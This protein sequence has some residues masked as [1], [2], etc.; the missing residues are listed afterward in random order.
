MAARRTSAARGP[1][2]RADLAH[3][4][5]L[6]MRDD[7]RRRRRESYW[8]GYG[9]GGMPGTLLIELLHQEWGAAVGSIWYDF[10]ARHVIAIRQIFV[11]PRFRRVG[12]ASILHDQLLAAYAGIERVVTGASD[13]GAALLESLGYQ[14]VAD[15][16]WELRLP[17]GRKTK[18]QA[19]RGRRRK[20]SQI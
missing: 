14:E 1:R 4:A 11:D 19:G 2:L 20:K 5:V 13:E 9:R 6:R 12:A 8:V 15:G 7:F 17:A 3:P 16:G 18:S 10:P